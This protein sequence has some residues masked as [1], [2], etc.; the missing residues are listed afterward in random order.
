MELLS[1]FLFSCL[2]AGSL[3]ADATPLDT[4]FGEPHI[5]QVAW[6]KNKH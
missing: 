5:G 1:Y 6:H 3:V 2:L 4:L